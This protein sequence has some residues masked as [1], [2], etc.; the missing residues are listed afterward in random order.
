MQKIDGKLKN[1][2]MS[3]TY[4]EKRAK[5]FENFKR[6]LKTLRSMGEDE[7]TYEYINAKTEFERRKN[8]STPVLLAILFLVIIAWFKFLPF[9]DLVIRYAEMIGETNPE[10]IMMVGICIYA[11][12]LATIT[13]CLALF[14]Y[15]LSRDIKALNIKCMSIECVMLER[16]NSLNSSDTTVERSM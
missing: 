8:F 16:R 9:M 5:E 7:I 11:L 13:I 1:Y 3:F 10:T 15:T 12:P 4:Q 14:S 6:E 2:I